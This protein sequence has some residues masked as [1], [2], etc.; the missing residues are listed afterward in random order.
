MRNGAN[1]KT[2][3]MSAVIN[4][5]KQSCGS[6]AEQWWLDLAGCNDTAAHFNLQNAVNKKGL[7]CGLS[8]SLFV[9][10]FIHRKGPTPLR[11]V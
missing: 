9:R 6:T 4:I 1:Y 8:K 5:L 10:K 11:Y 3:I 2:N 7:T